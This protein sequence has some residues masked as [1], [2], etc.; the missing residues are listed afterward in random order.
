MP[1]NI[2][3]DGL[4]SDI[5]SNEAA[6]HS[7]TFKFDNTPLTSAEPNVT[8]KVVELL[9]GMHTMG[10]SASNDSESTYNRYW[11]RGTGSV[12]SQWGTHKEEDIVSSVEPTV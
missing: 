8:T 6:Q 7:I 12:T 9:A 5:T 3:L 4:G 10:T 11:S 2:P 1:T